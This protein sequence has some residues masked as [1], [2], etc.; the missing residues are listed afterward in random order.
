[1]RRF[2][3]RPTEY[4]PKKVF[5]G[6][7]IDAAAK[8][9]GVAKMTIYRHWQSRADLLLDACSKLGKKGNTA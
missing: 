9:S 6:V 2:C 8:R 1:M 3:G 4:V 5:P 7:S